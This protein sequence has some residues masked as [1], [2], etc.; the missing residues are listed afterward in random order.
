MDEC[1]PPDEL[2]ELLTPSILQGIDATKVALHV[3]VA[4]SIIHLEKGKQS[5]QADCYLR[6]EVPMPPVTTT[7]TYHMTEGS[8]RLLELQ[9]LD[10]GLA[11]LQVIGLAGL[12]VIDVRSE[13]VDDAVTYDVTPRAVDR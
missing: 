11:G 10:L 3:G 8:V 2:L 6:L 9:H 5:R 1:H 4:K 13:R 12:Q 7:P